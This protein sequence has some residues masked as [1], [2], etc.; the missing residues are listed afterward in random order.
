MNIPLDIMCILW[1]N[2]I[3]TMKN[4]YIRIK[5]IYIKIKVWIYRQLEIPF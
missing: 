1:Y 4:I 2:M 3:I 5:N